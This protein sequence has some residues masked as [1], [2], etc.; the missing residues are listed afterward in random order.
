MVEVIQASRLSLHEIKQ[1]FGLQQIQDSQFFP[2]WQGLSS[3]L[4]AYEQHWLDQA[5][6]DFLSLAEYPLHE[7]IVKIAVLAPVL[8]IAGL[9]RAPFVPA[10]EKQ[11]EIA[12]EDEDEVIRGRVD[13]LV[14]Y[15]NLWV[16]T[17]ETK[18]KQ[19]DVL[20]ALPQALL[21]MMAS[22]TNSLPLFGLLTNGN[23]FLFVK[24]L[25]QETPSYG[26]SE[27]FTLL[28]QENDLYRVVGILKHLRELVLSEDWQGQQVG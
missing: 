11:V 18:P 5:K 24:L 4:T 3:D 15:R 7:E 22:P 21:Y 13:L 16:A 1:K 12:F 17:I 25:K 26:L 14:L 20:T 28:R 19:A 27:L 6:A 8:S 10:A 9:C 23:H 2:E